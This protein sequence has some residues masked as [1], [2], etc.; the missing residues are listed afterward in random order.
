MVDPMLV[1]GLSQPHLL[2]GTCKSR[3]PSTIPCGP[4]PG[5]SLGTKVSSLYLISVTNVRLQLGEVKQQ[6]AALV[7]GWVTA[8]VVLRRLVE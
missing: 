5:Y 2:A 4:P 3:R 7:N 8:I 6:L 1:S